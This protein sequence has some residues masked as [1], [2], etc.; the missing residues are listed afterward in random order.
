[1]D[2][3]DVE[4]TPLDLGDMNL[5]QREAL[6]L[7]DVACADHYRLAPRAHPGIERRL[8][9]DLR[10]D[11][12]RIAGRDRYFCLFLNEEFRRG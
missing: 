1:M 10:P 3:A 5:F 8:E 7:E 2:L 9:G 6:R 12:A 11:P 4:L